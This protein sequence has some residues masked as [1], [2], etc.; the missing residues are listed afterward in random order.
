[1]VRERTDVRCANSRCVRRRLVAMLE[2][3]FV[4]TSKLAGASVSTSNFC[5]VF[6]IGGVRHTRPSPLVPRRA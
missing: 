6:V 2:G 1:M 3:V 4:G 5:S